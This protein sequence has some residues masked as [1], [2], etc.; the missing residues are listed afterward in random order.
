MSNT[1]LKT[2]LGSMMAVTMPISLVIAADP[3]SPSGDSLSQTNGAP[4]VMPK[5]VVLVR[6]RDPDVVAA[7][8]SRPIPIKRTTQFRLE[9][10][11]VMFPRPTRHNIP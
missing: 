5:V 2:L 9:F 10:I 6:R 4:G 3:V 11:P 1:I 7:Q 8:T